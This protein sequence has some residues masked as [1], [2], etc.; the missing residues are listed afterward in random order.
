MLHLLPI[1]ISSL[2]LHQSRLFFPRLL[3]LYSLPAQREAAYLL[4]F[5]PECSSAISGS[6]IVHST[7]ESTCYHLAIGFHFHP[8]CLGKVG[9]TKATELDLKD[10][11]TKTNRQQKIASQ[12]ANKN[13]PTKSLGPPLLLKSTKISFASFSSTLPVNFHSAPCTLP[14]PH[15]GL[16]STP[17]ITAVLPSILIT[18]AHDGCPGSE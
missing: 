3:A 13:V 12:K 15:P 8:I 10:R 14:T 17:L 11:T 6:F 5:R 7:D 4:F 1:S 18:R 2:A 16:P 9:S